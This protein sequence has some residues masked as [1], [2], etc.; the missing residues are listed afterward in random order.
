MARSVPGLEAQRLAPRALDQN[1]PSPRTGVTNR[2]DSQSD[3]DVRR[4]REYI[5]ESTVE[6]GRVQH[7]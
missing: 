5:P 6:H 7:G 2:G 4:R 3:D 1:Q